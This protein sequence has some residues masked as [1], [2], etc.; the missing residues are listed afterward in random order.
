MKKLFVIGLHG[1]LYDSVGRVLDYLRHR[2]NYV[3]PRE[4]VTTTNMAAFTGIK[5]IDVDLLKQLNNPDFYQEMK[6]FDYS[7]EALNILSKYGNIITITR[8]PANTRM[9]TRIC[10]TRDFGPFIKDIYHQKN[11][12]KA[13]RALKASLVVEDNPEVAEQYASGRIVTFCPIHSYY[14]PVSTSRF[15]KPCRD[16]LQ[17]AKEYDAAYSQTSL[18]DGN[19]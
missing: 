3:M 1:V 13:A 10:A 2:W 7:W 12:P 5:E 16:I 15:L 11:G 14:K 17:V 9:I 18:G 8:R 4:S 19:A 6:P